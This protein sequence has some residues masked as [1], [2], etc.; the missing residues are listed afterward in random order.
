MGRAHDINLVVKNV[1]FLVDV[2]A[3][4]SLSEHPLDVSAYLDDP[5]SPKATLK[6]VDTLKSK[7]VEFSVSRFSEEDRAATVEVR[8]S[9]LS[10]HFDGAFFRL[11]FAAGGAEC[12]TG[13]IKSLSKK[14]QIRRRVAKASGAVSVER[15]SHLQA[16]RPST[17]LLMQ[18]LEKIVSEQQ[19]QRRLLRTLVGSNKRPASSSCPDADCYDLEDALKA[20]VSAYE[21]CSP[22]ERL[23]K[24][25]RVLASSPCAANALSGVAGVVVTETCL[26]PE[27]P[28]PVAPE[29]NEGHF[30]EVVELEGTDVFADLPLL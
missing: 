19:S 27:D 9:V 5:T 17:D 15:P 25:R 29:E 14:V 16:K 12:F 2:A 28:D 8:L 23:A 22:E 1:P 18:T 6:P 30:D 11:K 10:S 3:S 21:L 24:V 20:V 4:F 7:P 13:A 26:A